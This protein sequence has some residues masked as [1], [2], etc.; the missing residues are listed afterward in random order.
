[1]HPQTAA[2]S[3]AQPVPVPRAADLVEAVSEDDVLHRAEHVRDVSGVGEA[4]D[5]RVD[6]PAVRVEVAPLELLADPLDAG[7]VA[8]GADLHG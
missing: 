4:R 7:I 8:G 1:V 6:H 3:P 2:N 5:V